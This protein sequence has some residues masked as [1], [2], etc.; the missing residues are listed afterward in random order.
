MKIDFSQKINYQIE[1]NKPM[2]ETYIQ[3]HH[4]TIV[5][6]EYEYQ[7]KLHEK[8][9]QKFSKAHFCQEHLGGVSKNT[10]FAWRDRSDIILK[11][12]AFEVISSTETFKKS[13]ENYLYKKLIE[14][15][16]EEK[17]AEEIKKTITTN[18]LDLQIIYESIKYT[19]NL[20]T[21]GA[22]TKS[23]RQYIFIKHLHDLCENELALYLS[24]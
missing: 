9:N 3:K 6:E 2:I 22:I 15:D 7:K 24:T 1:K 18:K 16:P 8:S 20:L 23:E 11:K 10:F 4:K 5:K 19:E 21:K 13:Y 17:K 14:I 12:P